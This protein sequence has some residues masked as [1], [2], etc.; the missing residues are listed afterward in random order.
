LEDIEAGGVGRGKG[1][2][3][4]GDCD[5][6]FGFFWGNLDW[7]G[8]VKDGSLLGS[9]K[10]VALCWSY[11]MQMWLGAQ[12]SGPRDLITILDQKKSREG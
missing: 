8:Y 6:R 11:S 12:H 10:E 2:S 9:R 5:C 3:F 4:D 1:K 7:W